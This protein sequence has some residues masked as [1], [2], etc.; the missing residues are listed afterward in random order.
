MNSKCLICKNCGNVECEGAVFTQDEVMT[1]E[2][3]NGK[4]IVIEYVMY[5]DGTHKIISLIIDNQFYCEE[6]EYM[7]SDWSYYNKII[8]QVMGVI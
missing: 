7:I 3:N 6:N 4:N 5:P 8:D 1:I 2:I